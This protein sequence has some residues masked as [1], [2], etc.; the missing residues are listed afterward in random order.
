VFDPIDAHRPL[1][2]RRVPRPTRSLIAATLA[3]GALAA[4]GDDAPAG[5]IVT[6]PA[7]TGVATLATTGVR[8]DSGF[9]GETALPQL[10]VAARDAAGRPLANVPVAFAVTAGG[11]SVAHSVVHTRADGMAV[12]ERWILGDAPGPN[13]VTATAGR[14]SVEFRVRGVQRARPLWSWRRVGA[15]LGDRE[16]CAIDVDPLD[17]RTLYV[18]SMRRG[19][20]VSRDA[21]A[22]WTLALPGQGLDRG[23]LRV[24]PRDARVLWAA[25]ASESRRETELLVSTDQGRSWTPRGTVPE[26]S[27]RSVHVSA[28]EGSVYVGV[29]AEAGA[30]PGIYRSTDGGRT[31]AHHRLGPPAGTRTLPWQ[32]AEDDAGTLYVGTEIADHPQPYRPQLFRSTDRGVTWTDATGPMTWHVLRLG[33]DRRRGRVLAMTEGAGIYASTDHGV[34][35]TLLGRPFGADLMLDPRNPDVAYGGEFSI[36]GMP[37]GA[38]RTTDA[39]AT[40]ELIGLPNRHVGGFALTPSGDRLYACAALDGIWVAD[41]PGAE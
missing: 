35:W 10:I 12:Q 37:G 38:Y 6:P 20:Y 4:C 19:L 28:R 39:G 16:A 22:T 17:A 23:T 40:W 24:D 9:V 36:Y 18:S 3:G 7:A 8:R 31:F 32:I 33:I 29:Q 21:G 1:V 2:R 5:T 26:G 30:V 15:P 41:V 11:G 13:A 27:V 25:R 14:A 34:T